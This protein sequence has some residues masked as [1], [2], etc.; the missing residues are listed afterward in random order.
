MAAKMSAI[1]AR[2]VRKLT[3]IHLLREIR[4]ALPFLLPE[5]N[6]YSPILR[7]KTE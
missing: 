5:V 6:K 7:R 1:G 2:K 3:R 4:E